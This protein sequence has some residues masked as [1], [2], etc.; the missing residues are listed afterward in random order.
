MSIMEPHALATTMLRA[1]APMARK[2]LM[3]T[4]CT[5]NSSSQLM[6]NL[7]HATQPARPNHC[8]NIISFFCILAVFSQH[9]MM[10][11]TPKKM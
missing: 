10:W 1:I 4:L 6:K 9:C 3:A 7:Q 11:E 2:M 8:T 5:R